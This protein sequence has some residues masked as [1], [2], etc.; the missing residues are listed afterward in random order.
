MPALNFTLSRCSQEYSFMIAEGTVTNETTDSLKN[1]E[2][3]IAFKDASG[4]FVT[5]EDALIDYNPILPGQTSPFKITATY[6]PAMAT[7]EVSF[8]DLMGGTISASGG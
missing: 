7:C 3:V 6:N 2:A 4:N 8:K 1:V 5:S